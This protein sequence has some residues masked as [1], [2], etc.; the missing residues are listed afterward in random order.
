[1]SLP[2]GPIPRVAFDEIIEENW[3]DSVAQSLNNLAQRTDYL[4]WSPTA[5]M[6]ATTSTTTWTQWFRV[7][8]TTGEITVPDWA[9]HVVIQLH[10]SGIRATVSGNT[11]YLV[12]VDVGPTR[13]RNM[14]QTNSVAPGGWFSYIWN[15]VVPCSSIEGDRGVK[16]MMMR[17]GAGNQWAVDTDSRVFLQMTFLGAIGWYPGI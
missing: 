12:T 3:G 16:V 17:V 4:E 6:L 10:I 8:G 11:T 14:R 5:E 13:G 15:D 9:T 1:M 7:G 2:T